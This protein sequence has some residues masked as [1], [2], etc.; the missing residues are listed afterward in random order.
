[1]RIEEFWRSV[2]IVCLQKRN[3]EIQGYTM[4]RDIRIYR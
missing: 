3:N 2:L 4:D 1:M